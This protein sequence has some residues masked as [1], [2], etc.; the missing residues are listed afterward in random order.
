MERGGSFSGT[1][2]FL[3]M[4]NL[5]MLAICSE[6]TGVDQYVLMTVSTSAMMSGDNSLLLDGNFFSS[7]SVIWENTR[8]RLY[9]LSVM[10]GWSWWRVFYV[11]KP[12]PV[13]RF[14][15]NRQTGTSKIF[16]KND[17]MNHGGAFVCRVCEIH[18]PMWM[19]GSVKNCCADCLR[20]MCQCKINKLK[21]LK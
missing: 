16:I 15:L 13:M 14:F 9:M 4:N 17:T 20:Q 2:V 7:R 1:T 19:Q 11:C 6:V 12:K 8:M 3:S 18:K 21:Q 10:S 5:L